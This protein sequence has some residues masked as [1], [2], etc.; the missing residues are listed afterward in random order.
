[1]ATSAL[2][3]LP[4]AAL[5]AILVFVA[6]RLFRVAEMAAMW[7]FG[8]YEFALAAVTLLVVTFFGVE[9][10]V[11]AP[12]LVARFSRALRKRWSRQGAPRRAADRP[13]VG[14]GNE[15]RAPPPS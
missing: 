9:Q 11:V 12:A 5:G 8:P 4:E 13:R 14:F 6:F 3:Y 7:R 15:L 2:K 10:G 1:L